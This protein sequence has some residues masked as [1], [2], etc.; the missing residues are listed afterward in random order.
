MM[1]VSSKSVN[2]IWVLVAVAASALAALLGSCTADDESNGSTGTKP[3]A[4]AERTSVGARPAAVDSVVADA[5][6][7]HP[8]ATQPAMADQAAPKVARGREEFVGSQVCATCHRAQSEAF[9]NSHHKK[10]LVETTTEVNEARFGGEHFSTKNGG[11]TTFLRRAGEALVNSVTG[12]GKTAVLPV[13][14][15]SGVWPLQQYVVA[16]ERGKLQALGVVRDTRTTTPE[17]ERWL[18]VYGATGVAPNDPLFFTHAT[19]NWNHMCADCHSTWVARG[20]DVAS[21]SFESSWAELNVGCEACHGP[22][23]AHVESARRD[24]NNPVKFALS[25]QAAAPWSPSATGSPTPRAQR[26][27]EVEACA[28]CHSRR[29]P[30]A[31]GF[32]ASDLLLDHFEPELL[33]PGRYHADGQVEGEVYEWGSFTQSRMYQAGVTCSDCHD[34]H[35][36]KPYASGD[37]LCG[38]CH[39]P[40]RFKTPEHSHHSGANAPL[41][42]DCHMPKATFMQIDE[43]RDHSIRIPRPDH[44]VEFGTPNACTAC[45]TQRDATWA[46]EWTR[47]WYPTLEERSHFV[48]ALGKERHGAEVAPAELVALAGD[49]AKPAIA[50]ATA[51]ERLGHYPSAMSH[52]ALQRA[53]A[54]LRERH[55]LDRGGQALLVYGAVLGATQLPWQER[56]PLLLP[57]LEHEV[58]AVRIAAAEALASV[59]SNR[60]PAAS[61][62]SLERAFAE[63]EHSFDVSASRA[64]T[65]VER[66]A[67]EL[68]RG[69]FEQAERALQTALRLQP[70]LV[71]AELN[72]AE[73][74]RQKKDEVRAL[75]SIRS[76][77]ACDPNSAA[78][79][80]ALGLLHVRAKRQALALS[81]LTKAVELEPNDARFSYVLAVALAGDGKLDAAIRVL[82]ANLAR[83]PND[84]AS[85]S[86][87][88][89]YL[90][91]SGRSES[92]RLAAQRL[93]VLGGR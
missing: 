6:A 4:V 67:F 42:V 61:R 73:L 1:N 48:T 90:A 9:A 58:L 18:H 8:V 51:L 7:S 45:H 20:Y 88:S 59:P 68:A 15:V 66:S 92:A 84:V 89:R 65:H 23:K 24:P 53:L 57:A 47:K 64:E 32:V 50:R 28:P 52:E 14:Y 69:N 11:R 35:S 16:T 81:S 39:E 2:D 72:R 26:G 3:R 30:L 41:C 12:R 55:T 54:G 46:R 36:G 76:A 40:A 56:V 10:A 86:V 77:L 74:W 13:P 21:D 34:A 31:E 33:W 5:V 27:V 17:L 44:S 78:A 91:D 43:R 63:V 93:Q 37:A 25:L 71:E 19:Q 79:H 49:V 38:R 29:A 70:C 80:H 62:A 22:G 85:L 83:H 82:E 75:E 87:Y 60:V